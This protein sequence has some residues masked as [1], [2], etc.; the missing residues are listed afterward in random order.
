MKVYVFYHKNNT[1]PYAHTIDKHFRDRF[2]E[3]RNMDRFRY[4]KI[5]MDDEEYRE[6]VERYRN[7]TLD[8]FVYGSFYDSSYSNVIATYEEDGTVT[9]YC[10]EFDS[11]MQSICNDL[12]REPSIK[13]KDSIL[14]LKNVFEF[15]YIGNEKW[16]VSRIDSL[17]V[18]ISLFKNTLL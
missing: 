12:L 2:R 17:S 18:F 4:E 8:N 6:F 13:C 16:P 14:Y 1:Y 7:Q 5:K 9:D 15:R 10:N 11:E 3:Q